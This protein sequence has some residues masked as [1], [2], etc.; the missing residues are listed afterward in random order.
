M[1]K[2]DE[3]Y[4]CTRRHVG[5]HSECPDYERYLIRQQARRDARNKDAVIRGYRSGVLDKILKDGAVNKIKKER[6]KR[7]R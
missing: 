2:S 5:C 6:I 7:K 3:C 4:G 1:S